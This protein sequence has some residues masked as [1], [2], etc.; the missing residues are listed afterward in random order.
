MRGTVTKKKDRWYICYYTGEKLPSGRPKQK[1]EGSWPTKSEAERVLRSRISDLESR[2]ER[3][4]DNSTMTVFLRHWLEVYCKP[5]LARNTINAYTINVEK[6]M[7]PY[8]GEIQLNRLT[9]RDIQK[10][11]ESLRAAGLSGNSARHVHNNLH[12]ALLWAVKQE[13]IPRNPAD[14]VDPPLI[15]HK[16]RQTLTPEQIPRLLAACEGS[17]ICLPVTLAVTLGLRRGEA[18]GLQ[19]DDI[20]L[21]NKTVTIRHSVTCD[22]EGFTLGSPKTK[23]SRRT[24]ML[25]EAL[26]DALQKEQN[27]QRERARFIGPGFN[28]LRLVCCREDGKPITTN[29]LQHCF[30]DALRAA[31]LP[32]IRFHDLRHTNAT[33]MLRNHIPAKIVSAMLGHSGIGITMD[34][35]SHVTVDM[36]GGAV[37]VIN[38]LL[39]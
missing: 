2:Y 34:L 10:L 3:K 36:Q 19:W 6:H 1:W 33:L 38:Q 35:Y 23:S 26:V 8:I 16:E 17:F 24:L 12:R 5:R 13:L 29:A 39:K 9:P 31:G 30:K 20:D 18:L 14:L 32:D 21:A 37:Q 25:P 15:E 4:T 28:P 27:S 11:Y 22:K 7:V